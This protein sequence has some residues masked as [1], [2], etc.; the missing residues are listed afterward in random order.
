MHWE[1]QT[2][3]VKEQLLQRAIPQW[4]VCEVIFCKQDYSC[5]RSSSLFARSHSMRILSVSKIEECIEVNR[6]LEFV[7]T[8]KSKK[9]GIEIH[10]SFTQWKARKKRVIDK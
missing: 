8:R 1:E 7:E 3:F 10:Y 2:G 9:E 6:F 5:A 4:I